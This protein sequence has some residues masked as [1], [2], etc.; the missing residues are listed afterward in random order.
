IDHI[1]AGQA[2][3]IMRLLQILD[4]NKNKVTL[5]LNLASQNLGL[6]DLMKIENRV[7]TNDEANDIV[8][9]APEATINIIENFEVKHKITTHLPESIANVFLCPNRTCVTEK[10]SVK[11]LFHI[12]EQGKIV[13]LT[14]HYCEREYDRDEVKVNI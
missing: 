14:C 12:S 8:V 4:S 10:E 9:F 2:L 11:T 13:K 7:L 5:G 1:R 6:K 3:R